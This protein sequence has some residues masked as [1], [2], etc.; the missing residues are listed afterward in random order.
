MID[1]HV[2]VSETF[3]PAEAMRYGRAAG[4][5]ALGLLARVD[6]TT[7]PLLLPW[8]LQ[9]S[10]QYALYTGLEVFAGV[11]LVHI[12]PPIL[13]ESI[14]EARSLGAALVVVH[15]ETPADNVERGTN[16]AAIEA[17]AD[18]LA[19][20]GL[21]TDA[22]AERAAEIGTL[23]ELTTAPV[24]CLA[25]A[26]VAAQAMKF[27][28]GL[29]LNG[30]VHRKEDFASRELRQAALRGANLCPDTLALLEASTYTLFSRLVRI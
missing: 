24:H 21:L 13:P 23:L 2:H 3:L 19:H 11:E 14:A 17:G 7:L 20:P 28:C 8:L 4:Y 29:L 25:N 10:R 9:T 6:G 12:P 22:D 16:L 27:G 18:I 1:F 26:H 15:G 30:N 5:R